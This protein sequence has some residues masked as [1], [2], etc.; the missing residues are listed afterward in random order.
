MT[1]CAVGAVLC[2]LPA[3]LFAAPPPAGVNEVLAEMAKFD[4][5]YPAGKWQEASN[6]VDKMEKTIKEIFVQA[7]VDDFILEETLADLKKNIAAKN[8][9]GVNDAYIAFQK[10]YFNFV[11][12]F[13]HDVHPILVRI[14]Y[15]VLTAAPDAY[16]RQD[17]EDLLREMKMATILIDHGKVVL[18]NKGIPEQDINKFNSK[19]SAL[20]LAAKKGDQVQTGALLDQLKAE[21]GSFMERYKK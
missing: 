7:Q 20:N 16:T 12:H 11:S 14:E 6:A 10:Q 9:T 2:F 15:Y 5:S 13:D 8:A 18:M 1:V 4:E 19:V 17:Y 3:I 21:Y